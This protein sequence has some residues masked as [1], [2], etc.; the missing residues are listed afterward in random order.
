[1][2]LLILVKS[3]C[4]PIATIWFLFP[5]ETVKPKHFIFLLW[6]CFYLRCACACADLRPKPKIFHFFFFLSLFFISSFLIF[7]HGLLHD[8]V[9][10]FYLI[11]HQ[12]LIK[13]SPVNFFLTLTLILNFY[14]P[15]SGLGLNQYRFYW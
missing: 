15:T 12:E 13:G 11:I 1:M 6:L 5:L 10:S 7:S 8:F 2:N 14:L 9:L 4:L 3:N